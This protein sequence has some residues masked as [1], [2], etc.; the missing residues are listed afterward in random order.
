LVVWS[1]LAI[2]FAGVLIVTYLW[3][4]VIRIPG[5]SGIPVDLHFSSVL[6]A[7][8]A[9]L[10]TVVAALI[11]NRQPGN[12]LGWVI[13][14]IGYNLG[15]SAFSLGYAA[16]SLVGLISPLP[17]TGW[18]A[19]I[20]QVAWPVVYLGL[21]YLLLLF[22]AGVYQ[23]PGWRLVGWSV[24]VVVGIS[25][26]LLAFGTPIVIYDIEVD[27]PLG[28]I[29]GDWIESLLT[30]LF[31]VLLLAYLLEIIGLVLRY[32]RMSG[33]ERQQMKWV[34][35]ALA[36]LVSALLFSFITQTPFSSIL[37]SFSAMSFPIALGI[38][39]LRYRLWD[40]DLIIRKTLVYGLLTGALAF[41]YFGLVTLLQSL[42]ASVL[43]NQSPVIIVLTTLVLA[44]VFNPLR[45]RIQNLIDQRFYRRKYDAQKALAR[46]AEAA[47]NETDIQCLNEALLEVV[48][49]TMQP[50][51]LS[52][53]LRKKG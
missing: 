33:K 35:F 14:S 17:L 40:V 53:W 25:M 15:L 36:I 30:I 38:S 28:G 29:A 20:S 16:L 18:I 34:L 49:E 5:T 22:P 50:E 9:F 41:I 42:S 2:S 46:F 4:Q 43:G 45:T 21:S 32:R 23:G 24:T 19:W 7:L 48:Q 26:M 39:I 52:I 8:T 37:L 1:G 11:I 27:N 6:D 47:R 31:V 51:Q 12:R 3:L 10:I 13:L 44:V